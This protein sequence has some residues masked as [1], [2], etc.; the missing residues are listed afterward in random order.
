MGVCECACV[1]VCVYVCVCRCMCMQMCVYAN[2]CACM[3]THV[4]CVCLYVRA[5]VNT[6]VHCVRV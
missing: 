1:D 2:V 4:S 5:N 3:C 6:C